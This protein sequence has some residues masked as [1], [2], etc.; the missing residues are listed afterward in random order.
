MKLKVGDLFLN[1]S[2][3]L[4]FLYGINKETHYICGYNFTIDFWFDNIDD[5]H[6]YH[7]IELL[8]EV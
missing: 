3:H 6:D 4:V 8:N 7:G 1:T 5:E 2:N